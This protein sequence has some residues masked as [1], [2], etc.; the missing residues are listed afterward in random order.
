MNI[1][2]LRGLLRGALTNAGNILVAAG[3]LLILLGWYDIS[4]EGQVA[5]QIPYLVS[6]ALFGLGLVIAGAATRIIQSQNAS[7]EALV[8]AEQATRAALLQAI[9]QLGAAGLGVSAAQPADDLIAP[10]TADGLVLA[11]ASS[12]HRPDCRLVEGRSGA[13]VL[14]AAG[15]EAQ[16]LTPCRVCKPASRSDSQVGH[17]RSR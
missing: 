3:L 14:T 15:A 5:A 8:Q 4:Y 9:S 11:G 13:A 12:Y 17:V 7:R 10:D 6:D 1:T 2:I 16:G